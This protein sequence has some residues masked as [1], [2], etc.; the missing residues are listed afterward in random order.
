MPHIDLPE[1]VPGIRSLFAFRPETAK[2]L[3]ELAETLL[4]SPSSLA[5]GERE[6]IASYVSDRNACR[7]CTRSHSAFASA[8]LG[9]ADIVEK[10]KANPETAPISQK[11]KALLRI[12]GK[13]QADA[14]TVDK[15]DI[16]H[17]KSAG[18]TEVEIHDTVLIAAAFSMYNRYVD[19]LASWTPDDPAIYEGNAK[20]I[21][22]HGYLNIPTRV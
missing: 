20:R 14:R 8:Y 16:E 3:L 18:A 10:V 21:V 12:A 6:L 17:A 5:P 2:P 7:Y 13:V 15:G 4:R 22:S 9:D 11:L 19:G 1:G